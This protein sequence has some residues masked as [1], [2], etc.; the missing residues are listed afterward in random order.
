MAADGEFLASSTYQGKTWFGLNG[1]PS[2]PEMRLKV[3]RQ[4]DGA[5]T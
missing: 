2:E 1:H 5:F 3:I 4:G